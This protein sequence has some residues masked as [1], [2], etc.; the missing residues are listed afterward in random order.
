[1]PAKTDRNNKNVI[2]NKCAKTPNSRVV[3][4]IFI[5]AV[6]GTRLSAN[7]NYQNCFGL[8][9]VSYSAVPVFLSFRSGLNVSKIRD[10][11]LLIRLNYECEINVQLLNKPRG[12]TLISHSIRECFLRGDL[13]EL[14]IFL[15]VD[16]LLT[17]DSESY[18]APAFSRDRNQLAHEIHFHS[19]LVHL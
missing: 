2:K 10:K 1:M 19:L 13:G 18:E 16:L 9:L 17:G 7:N 4:V 5:T 6:N 12:N 3:T 8:L 15:A 14:W 11:L